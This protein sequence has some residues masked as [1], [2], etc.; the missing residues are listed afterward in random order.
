VTVAPPLLPGPA[1]AATPERTRSWS[2]RERARRTRGLITVLVLL[3]VATVIAVATDRHGSVHGLMDPDSYD[4]DGAHALATLLHDRGVEV[5]RVD[6]IAAAAAGAGSRTTV[7]VAD[8]DGEPDLTPL[9]RLPSGSTVVLVEPGS[10]ALSQVQPGVRLGGS[11]DRR[12]VSPA[13]NQPDAVLAGTITGE[14]DTYLGTGVS[15]Y[16]GTLYEEQTSSGGSVVDVGSSDTL[17]NQYLG[18]EG[19]AALGIGLLSHSSSVVW[20]VPGP[21]TVVATGRTP[22]DDLLP[23][24]LGWAIDQLVIA[25]ILLMLWRARRFGRLVQEPLPV[26][27]R[28]SETVEGLGRLYRAARSRRRAADALRH[29]ARTRIAPRLGLRRDDSATAVV[30]A[31]AARTGRPA[32]D[33]ATLL[34]GA[35][36]GDDPALVALADQLDALEAEVRRS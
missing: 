17:S 35:E 34:Y 19:N 16:S 32:A 28:A 2:G 36:P 23:S 29:A 24:R 18:N 25:V 12:V 9:G 5:T 14:G 31:V 27:V 22:L 30:E 13:C 26:S 6:N 7:V 3:I 15:C 4:Q 20:L 21:V 1:E 10:L 33:V 11:V 8:P